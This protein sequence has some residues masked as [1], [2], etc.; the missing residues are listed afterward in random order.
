MNGL[1]LLRARG[2]CKLCLQRGGRAALVYQRC[3]CRHAVPATLCCGAGRSNAPRLLLGVVS[4]LRSLHR[5]TPFAL[6][7]FP[8]SADGQ[9]LSGGSL[10][11]LGEGACKLCHR[12]GRSSCHCATCCAYHTRQCRPALA[13][14]S[15]PRTS[16]EK[17]APLCILLRLPR[18]SCKIE[19][20]CCALA[21]ELK[22]LGSPKT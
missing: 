5:L 1:S 8:V 4:G 21:H 3:C 11:L 9:E 14:L 20:A 13:R 6:R 10:H 7:A 12:G 16:K 19:V 17:I 18:E 15:P 2:V 22:P